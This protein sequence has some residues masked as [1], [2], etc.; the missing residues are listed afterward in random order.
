MG[1]VQIDHHEEG[2]ITTTRTIE[3]GKVKEVT[4]IAIHGKTLLMER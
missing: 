4:C 3:N 1:Y 2:R